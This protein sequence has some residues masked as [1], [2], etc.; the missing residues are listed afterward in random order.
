MLPISINLNDKI[1]IISPHPDD[2]CIGTGGILIK[3]AK[4]CSVLLLTDGCRYNKNGNKNVNAQI[5]HEEFVAEM[6][7]AG[8]ADYYEMKIEDA[9]LSEHLDRVLG[10]DY[11]F[12][13]VIFVP[14]MDDKHTDH[15]AAYYGLTK[16]LNH[17]GLSPKVYEYEVWS[18]FPDAI[19]Y[20]DISDAINEKMKLISFH[21]SQ[22]KELDYVT[23]SRSLAEYRGAQSKTCTYAE[24]Y[25]PVNLKIESSDYTALHLSKQVQ[26]FQLLYHTAAQWL[27]H[28]TLGKSIV[29]CLHKHGIRN[30]AI[31]GFSDLGECLYHLL[32]R[33]NIEIKYILDKRGKQMFSKNLLIKT[34]NETLEMVDIVIVTALA[35]F[36][37]IKTELARKGLRAVSLVEMLFE[38][39]GL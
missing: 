27:K 11:S 24:V 16:A 6:Q 21:K 17:N 3:Y 25:R 10:F 8:I 9:Q 32:V 38:M 22:L 30:V 33:T 15:R 31:Y 4:Q 36:V 23:M 1:L 19:E 37:E 28:E 18:P 14:S 5:R 39:K 29:R 7:Y 12:Y 2:E 20:L 26:K 34:P 35:D 13:D